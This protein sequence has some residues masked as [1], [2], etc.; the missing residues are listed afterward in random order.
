MMAARMSRSNCVGLFIVSKTGAPAAKFPK[1]GA[2]ARPRKIA[3]M[4]AELAAD[5]YACPGMRIGRRKIG[6]RRR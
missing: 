1:A 2:A 3:A 6:R 4:L 5:L